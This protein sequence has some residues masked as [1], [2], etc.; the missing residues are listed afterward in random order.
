MKSLPNEKFNIDNLSLKSRW[1]RSVDFNVI[2]EIKSP[3]CLLFKSDYNSVI[4]VGYY[5]NLVRLMTNLT[6]TGYSAFESYVREFSSVHGVN[7]KLVEILEDNRELLNNKFTIY[8]TDISVLLEVLIK[9]ELETKE[10]VDELKKHKPSSMS[11][12]FRDFR[13]LS[14]DLD[15]FYIS[16]VEMHESSLEK[17][18]IYP[19]N[20]QSIMGSFNLEMHYKIPEN[21]ND[22]VE[23]LSYKVD[24]FKLD[25]ALVVAIDAF[26]ECNETIF[27]LEQY[28]YLSYSMPL[29]YS[30]AYDIVF[31][32]MK[33]LV[34]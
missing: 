9:N 28:N 20:H 11:R 15:K 21:Y 23:E 19:I 25:Y 8:D 12:N 7:L 32:R 17:S 10:F 14:E 22:L 27:G 33:R 34:L 29:I 6:L 13:A 30:F 26:K 24:A 16:F 4:T 3:S 1:L 2:D 31:L 18:L 5:T